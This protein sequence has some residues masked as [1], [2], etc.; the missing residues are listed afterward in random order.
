M[1]F[2]HQSK[3]RAELASKEGRKLHRD[4]PPPFLFLEKE[5]EEKLQT[6]LISKTLDNKNPNMNE[7]SE[8][9]YIYSNIYYF[10]LKA[11]EIKSKRIKKENSHPPSKRWVKNFIKKIPMLQMTKATIMDECRISALT[12]SNLSSYFQKF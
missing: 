11:F 3:L 8:L 4:G 12:K 10:Y 6:V 9:V 5:E 7:I 2:T 1:Y